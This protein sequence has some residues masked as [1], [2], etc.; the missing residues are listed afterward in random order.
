[1]GQLKYLPLLMPNS[2]KAIFLLDC[3]ETEYILTE[4]FLYSQLN[5]VEKK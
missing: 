4:P 3:F 5:I 2:L 1:M